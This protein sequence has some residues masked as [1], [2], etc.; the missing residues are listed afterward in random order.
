MDVTVQ[1]S[2]WKPFVESSLNSYTLDVAL[3]QFFFSDIFQELVLRISSFF[4]RT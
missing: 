1:K 4:Q 2:S 3:K